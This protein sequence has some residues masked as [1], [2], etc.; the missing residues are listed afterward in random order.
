M[1]HPSGFSRRHDLSH[2]E[3]VELLLWSIHEQNEVIIDALRAMQQPTGPNQTAALNALATRIDTMRTKAQS[4]LSTNA[5]P[6]P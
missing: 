3:L 6:A 2:G 4:A 5:P 1:S